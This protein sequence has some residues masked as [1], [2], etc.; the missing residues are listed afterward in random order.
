MQE[1]DALAKTWQKRTAAHC[2]RFNRRRWEI[3]TA[4]YCH[5]TARIS[6]GPADGYGFT[7]LCVPCVREFVIAS[8]VSRSQRTT[9][10]SSVPPPPT[11]MHGSWMPQA[12]PHGRER[13]NADARCAL[14][15]EGL[16]CHM[17]GEASRASGV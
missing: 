12:G 4:R 10:Q 15:L 16:T 3:T 13:V 5:D 7:S 8:L 9:T 11:C 14:E 2:C 17:G 1:R 6:G